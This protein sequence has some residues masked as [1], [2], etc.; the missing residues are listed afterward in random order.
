MTRTRNLLRGR[1]SN[2][3]NYAPQANG[4]LK[5]RL[6]KMK[7][8]REVFTRVGTLAEAMAFFA[9]FRLGRYLKQSKAS[10]SCTGIFNYRLSKP[11]LGSEGTVYRD[12]LSRQRPRVRVP[13]SPPF[14]IKHLEK[15]RHSGV[16]T[17]RYQKGTN[18]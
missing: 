9:E 3:L 18:S 2:Q 8:Q 16:G 13:S 7:E 14:Q 6:P 4:Q 17:K 1:R 11:S 10:A 15:W 5:T 12:T